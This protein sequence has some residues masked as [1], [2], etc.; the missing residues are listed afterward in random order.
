MTQALHHYEARC[1]RDGR[2]WSVDVPELRIHT[3]GHTLRD[4]ETMACDAIATLL[5]VS[6]E[7][8]SVS[9]DSG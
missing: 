5:G 2:S 9:L 8:V 6:V 1:E 4:A 7:E 3:F